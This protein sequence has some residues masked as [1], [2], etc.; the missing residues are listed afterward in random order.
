MAAVFAAIVL[1]LA[2]L[3]FQ[4]V[5]KRAEGEWNVAIVATVIAF[6]TL[7]AGVSITD[8]EDARGGETVFSFIGKLIAFAGFSYATIAAIVTGCLAYQESS[9]NRKSGS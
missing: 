5:H 1:P 4:S 7:W 6:L 3:V 8:W 9:R 2:F